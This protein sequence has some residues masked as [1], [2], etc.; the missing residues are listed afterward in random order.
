MHCVFSGCCLLVVCSGRV[1]GCLRILSFGD[2]PWQRC[3]PICTYEKVQISSDHDFRCLMTSSD[4]F[5]HFFLWFVSF[6]V[7]FWRFLLLVSSH[8]VFWRCLLTMSSDDVFWRCLLTL[9]SAVVFWWWRCLPEMMSYDVS[10]LCLLTL[11]SADFFRWVFRR[12][13]QMV[14]PDMSSI[15]SD[16][17]Y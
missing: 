14:F 9:S 12:C 5:R 3:L 16:N 11:S 6:D 4:D 10:W 1:F 7:V 15:N 2:V 17:L 8:D 13:L